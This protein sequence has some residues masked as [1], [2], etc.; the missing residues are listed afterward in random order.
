MPTVHVVVTDNL[1][2]W[3]EAQAKREEVHGSTSRYCARV[4]MDHRAR[5]T[6]AK[7]EAAQSNEPTEPEKGIS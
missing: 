6:A 1:K 7:R 4:L 2:R 3:L 5:V